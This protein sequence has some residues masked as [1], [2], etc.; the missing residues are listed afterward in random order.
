[1][2]SPVFSAGERNKALNSRVDTYFE[3]QPENL[4][5]A[6]GKR[7]SNSGWGALPRA[8]E[9]E[10]GC[11]RRGSESTNSSDSAARDAVAGKAAKA[12]RAARRKSKDMTSSFFR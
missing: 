12:W 10:L 5:E 7:T 4:M 11:D 1:L 8:D 9:T 3:A 2:G 6:R